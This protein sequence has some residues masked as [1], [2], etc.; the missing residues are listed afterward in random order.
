MNE[1]EKAEE[2]KSGAGGSSARRRL[3]GVTDV[4]RK[5]GPVLKWIVFALVV[6]LVIIFVLRGALQFLAGFTD[7]ARRLLEALRNFWAG[8]FAGWGGR[9]AAGG[10][11]EVEE[12]EVPEPELPFSSFPNPFDTGTAGRWPARQL[13]RYTFEAV[14][15]W[16]RERDLGRQVGET[17][18]EFSGRVGGEVPALEAE[19]RQLAALFARAAYAREPLPGNTVEVLRRFWERL[20]RVAAAP[21]S[22]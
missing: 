4:L 3:A 11:E 14:Q 6:V 19:L 10:A 13:V 15:A 5:V 2:R 8:L 16:A 12:G 17:P 22:A 7:W 1:R 21:L 20:E 18:L 9:Q